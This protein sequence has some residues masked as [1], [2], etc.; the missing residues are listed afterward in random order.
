MTE[1]QAANYTLEHIFGPVDF[2]DATTQ[3]ETSGTGYESQGEPWN[4]LA[5][6]ALL[7]TEPGEHLPDLG[8]MREDSPGNRNGNIA[9][10]R[11]DSF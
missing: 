9:A 7:P 11:P 10:R 3:P 1:E 5:Q 2:W 8:G 4:P 6:L